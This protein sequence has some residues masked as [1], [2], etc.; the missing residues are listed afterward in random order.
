M[1]EWFSQIRIYATALSSEQYMSVCCASFR[2]TVGYTMH[3]DPCGHKIGFP[4]KY[5]SNYV[6]GAWWI[7]VLLRQRAT[8]VHKEVFPSYHVFGCSTRQQFS[9]PL[10]LMVSIFQ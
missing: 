8:G 2:C 3:G 1:S 5:S 4:V 7:I 10:D 6:P 9:S